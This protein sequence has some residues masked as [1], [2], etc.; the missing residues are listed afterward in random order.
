MLVAQ[1][2]AVVPYM[3]DTG[4]VLV[5]LGCRGVGQDLLVKGVGDDLA[6][7]VRD[8]PVLEHPLDVEI[9][10]LT[11]S[12]W[13]R[14]HRDLLCRSHPCATGLTGPDVSCGVRSCLRSLVFLVRCYGARA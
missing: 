2:A 8:R 4:P 14:P 3:P 10:R 1:S 7:G 11:G 12:P 9:E 6:D 5:D 13:L